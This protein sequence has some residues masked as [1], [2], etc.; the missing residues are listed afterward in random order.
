M[1]DMKKEAGREHNYIDESGKAVVII[2]LL[3]FFVIC[4]I[5]SKKSDKG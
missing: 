5:Q 3:L 1:T 2:L 4:H